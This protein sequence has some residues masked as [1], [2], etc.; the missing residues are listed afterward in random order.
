[1]ALPNSGTDV[2]QVPAS[3]PPVALAPLP[4]QRTLLDYLKNEEPA[5]WRWFAARRPAD[6]AA[7]SV[8]LELLKSTYRLEPASQP[9]LYACA[10]DV[11]VRLGLH[12]PI[13]FYQAQQ[14]AAAN[15]AL[16]YLPGEAHIILAGPLLA[17]LSEIECRAMV[18]HELAHFLLCDGW[19]GDYR[20]AGEMLRALSQDA[21][22][23]PAAA[24]SARL[25]TLYGEL[26]ADRGAF[27]VTGDATAT[28]T[29]LLKL[30]TGLAEV[31][32]ESYLRQAEEIFRQGAVQ[33]D[34]PTHPE[35]YI[36]ARALK[37]WTDHGEAAAAEIE[38]M[39]EGPL[40]FGRLDLLA[41]RKVAQ[42]T[43][44]LI[45]GLLA[46]P[47]LRTEPV[48]AHAHRFFDDFALADVAENPS[49]EDVQTED[50]GLRDYYDYVLLDFVAVARELEDLPLA[51]ALVT[52]EPLGL[53]DRLAELAVKE[54]GLTKKHV[55][56]VRQ[57]A[58]TMLAQVEN[59][60][61]R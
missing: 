25:F 57:E 10:E 18:G 55:T 48:L 61:P 27:A 44:R 21:G 51:A 34:G 16:A 41:R 30:E 23:D 19:D 11:Q 52:G 33:A 29:T 43:R 59:R 7:E 9:A 28:I 39:I 46:R 49:L 17:Q 26:F 45:A 53:A 56:R 6:S 54:L 14:A 20:T 35:P 2:P 13:T 50:P 4:Y 40:T 37:L 47:W 38:R 12:V 36:R 5:L 3:P 58:P 22:A 32:A 60:C 24:E 31:S 15:A 1:M 8:R 42:R